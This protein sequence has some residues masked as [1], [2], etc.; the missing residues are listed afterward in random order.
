MQLIKRRRER[1]GYSKR[2]AARLAG[3]S[4]AWWRYLEAGSR[5]FKGIVTPEP[6]NDRAIARMAHVVRVTPGELREYGHELAADILENL[7]AE[8]AAD[9]AESTQ[10][11]AA[12]VDAIEGLTPRQRERLITRLAGD[13]RDLE[14]E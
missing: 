4:E 8:H 13:L 2:E 10:K 1:L 7:I 9:D 11:A 14:D 12:A 6:P 5:K 3:K